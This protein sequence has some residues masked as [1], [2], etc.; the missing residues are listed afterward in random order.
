V[1]SIITMQGGQPWNVLDSGNDISLTGEGNDRWNFFGSPADFTSSPA[2]IPFFADGTLN[3]DCATHALASQLQ[4]FGCFAKG[5][6]VMTP[7]NPGSFGSMGRN[8]FRGTGLKAW[9]LSVVK[10]W[11][12]AERLKLQFRGEFFNIFNHPSFANPYGVNLN[13]G[14][15]DPSNSAQFGC[16]CATPDVGDANPVI[17]TGGPRNIQLGIKMVF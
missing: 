9:D 10:D 7:P 11:K 13:Y 12:L 2:P 5:A 14:R 6:S 15:V 17:G 16:A 1:N 4:Q 3:A 8:I